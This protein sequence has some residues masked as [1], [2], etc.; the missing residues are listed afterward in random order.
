MRTTEEPSQAVYLLPNFD[1]YIVGY[2]DRSAIFD[3]SHTHKLGPRG[4]VL[5]NHTI[6]MEGR[7]VG[8]WNRTIKKDEVGVTPVF[9]APLDAAEMRAFAASA[10]RY[11]TFLEKKVALH[12]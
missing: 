6:V 5:F 2:T 9:F 12:V 11:S 4:N 3:A 7:V 10:D 1:E 8:T